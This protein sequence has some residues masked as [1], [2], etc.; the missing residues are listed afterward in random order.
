MLWK[1][2]SLINMPKKFGKENNHK[3]LNI[4]MVNKKL[5]QYISAKKLALTY[6]LNMF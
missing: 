5:S 3:L 1:G 6:N 2:T 4:E